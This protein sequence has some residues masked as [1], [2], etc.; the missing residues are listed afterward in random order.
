[1]AIYD[2]SGGQLSSANAV[3]GSAI[4]SAYDASGTLIFQSGPIT[5]KVMTYNVGGWRIGSGT[6]VPA[7][8][9]AAYY[10]LQNAIIEGQNADILALEEYWDAFSPN[11]SASSL[12]SQ[13]YPY[14]E[15]RGGSTRYYGRAICSKY[16]IV[17]YTQHFFANENQRYYDT[18]VI[19][20]DGNLVS[21][22]VTHLGLTTSER[23]VQAQ[24]LRSYIA[25]LSSFILCGD[26]N[27]TYAM[28][29]SGDESE[30]YT[31]VWLPFIEAGYH[32]ANCSDEN[33][34]H[35]TYWN[36]EKLIWRNLDNIVTS[37]N[38]L[39]TS[40]STDQTKVTDPVTA[41]PEWRRDHIP[42]IAEVEIN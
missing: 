39:I 7:E 22:I 10:A 9:D 11:R 19:N 29:T 18:A 27:T 8:Y 5:L 23:V 3:D 33:G 36:Y 35:G 26:F 41:D 28:G 6:N 25:N 20:I 37:H 4:N 34:F 1:M 30:E 40:V 31:T 38:I 14:I 32:L 13:Y 16:P 2:L 17:S 12:L 15:T 24:E 21:V 42:L